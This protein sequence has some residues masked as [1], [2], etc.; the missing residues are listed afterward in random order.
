[1]S[2]DNDPN[3]IDPM[4]LAQPFAERL[5]ED[6]GLRGSLTDTG[7]A[8]LLEWLTNLLIEAAGR[9]AEHPDPQAEMERAGDAARRLGQAIVTASER[10][11]ITTIQPELRDPLLTDQQINGVMAALPKLRLRQASPDQRAGLIVAALASATGVGVGE[12]DEQ[13]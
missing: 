1:M 5:A 12:E 8:P 7:Y 10:N 3:A 11:D 6:E 13:T 4:D 2:T 9:M